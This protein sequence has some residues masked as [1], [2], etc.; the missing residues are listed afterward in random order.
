MIAYQVLDIANSNPDA[1]KYTPSAEGKAFGNT[2]GFVAFLD[3]NYASIEKGVLNR[4]NNQDFW[5]SSTGNMPLSTFANGEKCFAPTKDT[6]IQI[7]PKSNFPQNEWSV[8]FVAQAV[9]GQS[10]A[11]GGLMQAIV[12]GDSSADYA[13]AV[14]FFR[15]GEGLAVMKAGALSDGTRRL[16]LSDAAIKGVTKVYVVSFSAKNGLSIY[17]NGSKRSSVL[18]TNVI[19]NDYLAGKWSILRGFMGKAGM[20]GILS[21]DLSDATNDLYRNNITNFL[22][23]KYGITV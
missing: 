16:T 15:S 5:L 6:L 23:Q 2:P 17:V 7:R 13:P 1:V 14:R 9:E 22:I 4:V 12:T 10:Q 3:P 19:A 21:I 11:E 20:M 8:F 18:D